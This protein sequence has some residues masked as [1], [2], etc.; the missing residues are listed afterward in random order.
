MKSFIKALSL[1]TVVGFFAASCEKDLCKD[2]A[3]GERGTCLEGVVTCDEGYEK[4]ADGLC[5]VESRAKFIGSFNADELCDTSTYNYIVN[6][7]NNS[8]SITKFNISDLYLTGTNMV[9]DVDASGLAFTIN[10]Q[11]IST[12]L[13]ATGSGTINANT[14]IVTVSYTINDGSASQSCSAILS[15]R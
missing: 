9:C 2:V 13:T 6:V 5:D 1:L 4:N 7:S 10:N 12:G 15:P 3:T 11:T 14:R 8:T